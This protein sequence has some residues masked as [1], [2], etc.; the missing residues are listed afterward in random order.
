M[1]LPRVSIVI[2]NHNYDRFLSD[3][4]SSALTQRHPVHEVIVVDDGSTDDSLA[5]AR[6]FGNQITLVAQANGGQVAAYNTGLGT[7]SGDVVIFL[8]SD[9]RL[10]PDAVGAVAR[11]MVDEAVARVHFRLALIGPDGT[12]KGSV[13]PTRMAEGDLADTVRAGRLFFA[14]PGSGNAYRVS[15]LRRL[16]PIPAHRQDR[17]G[18]DFF[19][20]YGTALLGRVRALPDALAEYRVH[21]D[22][23]QA[24]LCF[25]NAL[26]TT[27]VALQANRYRRLRAWLAVAL[28]GE[29]LAPD[30]A[31]DF[32]LQKQAF[33]SAIYTT[34]SYLTG[35]RSGWQEWPALWQSIRI[36]DC[37]WPVKL[38]LAGWALG[39]WLLPR[40][41]GLPLARYVCNPSSRGVG[42]NMASRS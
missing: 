35:L 40:R 32:S 3:A 28:P 26:G 10:R 29:R 36:R 22:Q 33:A 24:S 19:A 25:G 23:D 27:R 12:A 16:M 15:A 1:S 38:A 11:A 8:D 41:L 7:V 42:L 13:I 20:G 4:I 14:A 39:I 34:P 2:C 37:R 5:I 9:D 17:H 18:A 31:A 21:K 6:R 30:V